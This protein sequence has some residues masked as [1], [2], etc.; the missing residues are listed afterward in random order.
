VRQF[1]FRQ[2]SC[3]FYDRNTK[4]NSKKLLENE[5]IGDNLLQLLDKRTTQYTKCSRKYEM[6]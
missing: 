6:G 3:V 4:T 2:E 5:A 1:I